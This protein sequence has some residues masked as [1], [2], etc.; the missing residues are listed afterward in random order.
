MSNRQTQRQVHKAPV[1]IEG[2]KDAV[3]AFWTVD[4]CHIGEVASL[5]IRPGDILTIE[6]DSVGA[7]SIEIRPLPTKK[8]SAIVRARLERHEPRNDPT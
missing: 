2:S 6:A 7:V 8:G 1:A 3:L 5:D 4:P